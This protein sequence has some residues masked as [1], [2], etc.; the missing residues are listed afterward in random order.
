LFGIRGKRWEDPN[1]GVKEWGIPTGF[2][3]DLMNE[4][5]K[6]PGNAAMPTNA[7]VVEGACYW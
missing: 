2:Y 5:W 7:Q 3:S 6:R 4:H 1:Y